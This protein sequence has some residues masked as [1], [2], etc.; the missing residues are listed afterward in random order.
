M[1]KN[2]ENVYDYRCG[3]ISV[4]TDYTMWG[5][6]LLRRVESKDEGP[7]RLA[8]EVSRY[9]FLFQSLKSQKKEGVCSE[10]H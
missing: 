6:L 8:L 1:S 3:N 10:F 4:P 2:K 5:D 9:E 7:P